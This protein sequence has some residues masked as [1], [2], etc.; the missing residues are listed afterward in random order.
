MNHKSSL[1]LKS[2]GARPT[3]APRLLISACLLGV[4]CRYDGVST[5]A[6]GLLIKIPRRLVV[7]ACPEQ[8]GGLPTPRPPATIQGGDG[9][10]VLDG[11]ARLKNDQGEDVTEAFVR[12]AHEALRLARL[13]G[14]GVALLKDKSPSCGTLTPYCT[15]DGGG[16]GVTAALLEKEGLRVFEIRPDAPFP[17]PGLDEIL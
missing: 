4:C 3:E 10:D 6:E 5:G 14:A 13:C 8:L 15:K 11:R 17:P 1:S 9:R 7:A 2:S 16:M 12:G